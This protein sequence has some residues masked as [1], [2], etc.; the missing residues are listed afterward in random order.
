MI[1]L[2]FGLVE[3]TLTK[4][5][6]KEISDS[7]CPIAKNLIDKLKRSKKKKY[8]VALIDKRYNMTGLIIQYGV[9]NISY[10]NIETQLKKF[11]EK[12]ESDVCFYALKS[13]TPILLNDIFDPSCIEF[14]SNELSGDVRDI[15]ENFDLMIKLNY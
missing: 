15:P 10:N 9:L 12:M 8:V 4:K 2:N 13:V 1:K 3:I 6:I 14:A 7:L 5:V 11:S